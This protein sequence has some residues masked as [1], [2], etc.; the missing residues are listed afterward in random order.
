MTE[1]TFY[2]QYIANSHVFDLIH[3]TTVMYLA[4]VILLT[5]TYL[6]LHTPVYPFSVM[7]LTALNMDQSCILLFFIPFD[8]DISHVFDLKNVSSTIVPMVCWVLALK[9]M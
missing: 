2:T 8:H 3:A 6:F 5:E 1:L 7:Y 9:I 4:A